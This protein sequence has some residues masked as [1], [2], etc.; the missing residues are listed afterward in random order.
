ML[1]QALIDRGDRKTVLKEQTEPFLYPEYDWEK[2]G[3]TGQTTVAN[4]L[5]PFQGKWLL[6]YGGADR[7]IGLATCTMS[8]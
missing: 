6:H 3:F 2:Y 8:E 1:R 7:V 5:V 4:S